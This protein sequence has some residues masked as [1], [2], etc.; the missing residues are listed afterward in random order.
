MLSRIQ[1]QRVLTKTIKERKL[2][3]FGHLVRQGDLQRK[4][5]EAKVTGKRGRGR[6][7]TSWTDNIKNWTGLSYC[8]AVAMAQNRQLWRIISSNPRE[9]EDG[10]RIR[11]RCVILLVTLTYNHRKSN[12]LNYESFNRITI[13]HQTLAQSPLL[14][15]LNGDRYDSIR[16]RDYGESE[17]KKTHSEI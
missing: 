7:K 12:H 17:T 10:T 15:I 16:R 5:V 9:T 14:A 13:R 11:R 3:Y 1:S 2:Q 6:P 4:L 8:E